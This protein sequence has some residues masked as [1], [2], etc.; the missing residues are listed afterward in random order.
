[1]RKPHTVEE[2]LMLPVATDMLETMLGESYAINSGLAHNAAGRRL[3]DISEDLCDQSAHQLKT[4]CSASRWGGGGGTGAFTDAHLIT[5]LL[6]MLEMI[7]RRI[8]VLFCLANLLMVEVRHW[9][10]KYN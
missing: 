9:K 4:F 8:T 5:H 10:F 3:S 6:Y 2:I 1:M 7:E